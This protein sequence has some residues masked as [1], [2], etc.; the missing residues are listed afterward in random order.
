MA[1]FWVFLRYCLLPN[2]IEETGRDPETGE[3]YDDYCDEDGNFSPIKVTETKLGARLAKI[4]GEKCAI[5]KYTSTIK[6]LPTSVFEKYKKLFQ[7][8]MDHLLEAFEMSSENGLIF[9]FPVLDS[10]KGKTKEEAISILRE[11]AHVAISL[12]NIIYKSGEH[13][14]KDIESII[15][16]FSNSEYDS[17]IDYYRS[18]EDYVLENINSRTANIGRWGESFS[19]IED[20][21]IR[22]IEV[23]Y[24][25]IG[26]S[27]RDESDTLF[28]TVYS[29]L[30][31]WQW[32]E[33]ETKDTEWF[34]VNATGKA[35]T[36]LWGEDNSLIQR[37]IAWES[38]PYYS[39][40]H[41]L[42]NAYKDFLRFVLADCLIP[43]DISRFYYNKG[44][45][46]TV[47]RLHTFEENSVFTKVIK[48]Y[49]EG[50]T[51]LIKYEEENR[52]IA[53][54]ESRYIPDTFLNKWI[55]KL[56]ICDKLEFEVP[57]GLGFS[58]N[59]LHDGYK[60]QLADVG[61][62]ITQI[63]IFLMQ[64]EGA[65]I[66][67]EI[68]DIKRAQ[69]QETILPPVKIIG[70][71]EPEVS[72]HPCFQ[73]LLA[74][75]LYDAL[76]CANHRLN[77]IVETHSEYLIRKLQVIVSRFSKDEFN[78]NPF[79]VYYFDNNG[80]PRDLGF[81]ESGRFKESFGPGFFDEAAHS[82]YLL[83][84]PKNDKEE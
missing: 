83:T 45:F 22:R 47:R 18:L 7:C 79:A 43:D 55:S 76:Q 24:D 64:I 74:D 11:R 17:F 81:M 52:Y 78:N 67:N 42:Y 40:S 3:W 16:D 32:A 19:F 8:D 77:F 14:A 36:S 33:D 51:Y 72:L 70:L 13:F 29:V 54:K 53:G 1:D 12:E 68:L 73:S 69:K 62:G 44:S 75:M 37:S 21:I 48:E 50:R 38:S 31:E 49:L 35:I 59:L 66:E 6:R 34:S 65:L 57:L 10:F 9:Y 80:V 56:N 82:K 61:H 71:E 26:F 20:H 4:Q 39:S 27:R 28:S 41:I 60:E 15:Q 58:L 25:N 63:I 5:F 23:A 46:T 84:V 30:S 2:Y